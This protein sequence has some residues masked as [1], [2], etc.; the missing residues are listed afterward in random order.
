MKYFK[1]MQFSSICYMYRQFD[2]TL[3]IGWNSSSN[4]CI[5]CNH[6]IWHVFSKYELAWAA[7][8]YSNKSQ[9]CFE[10]FIMIVTELYEWV[11]F[12]KILN[13]FVGLYKKS[14]RYV[15]TPLKVYVEPPPPPRLLL[16][17]YE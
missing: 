3:L 1:R 11:W 4:T 10:I 5:I 15:C 6:E 8:K 9:F 7:I 2:I 14:Q 12:K 17:L 16:P 13:I